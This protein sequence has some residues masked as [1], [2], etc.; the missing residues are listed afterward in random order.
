MIGHMILF[1]PR[2]GLPPADL[3]A[4]VSA[5]ERALKEIPGIAGS[6]VGERLKIG[7]EYESRNIQDFPYAAFLEFE[8]EQ[9]LRTYL[10]HPAHQEL[11]RRFYQTAEAALAFDFVLREAGEVRELLK[12]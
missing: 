9:D 10:D 11:G 1:R 8:T 12:K 4:L 3:E 2:P 5:I 6:R 7:R